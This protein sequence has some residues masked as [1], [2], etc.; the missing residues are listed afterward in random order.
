MNYVENS[1]L[2]FLIDIVDEDFVSLSASFYSEAEPEKTKQTF[3][4][5]LSRDG[6][7]IQTKRD[8][9]KKNVYDIL[10]LVSA[11]QSLPAKFCVTNTLR[12]LPVS[13]NYID[14]AALMKVLMETRTE[15]LKCQA[16]QARFD[17][18]LSDSLK[19]Q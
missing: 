17:E 19:A 9:R 5:L 8:A 13:L 11:T 14:V 18:N 16:M 10:R 6:D 3:N 7:A 1:V 4:R 12:L 2:F 15:L